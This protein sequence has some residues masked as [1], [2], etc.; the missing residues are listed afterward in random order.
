MIRARNA[1]IAFWFASLI[2]CSQDSTSQ[3]TRIRPDLAKHFEKANVRGSF[4]L[5]EMK[6]DTY[7]LTDTN[8]FTQGFT[9]ASTFKI[10]NSLIG[11]ETGVI[12]DENFVIQWDGV[13][14]QREEWNCDQDLK[15]A[16]KNSTVPY[17]QE[18]ARRV[19][20]ERMKQWLDNAAYGNGDTS[21]G[22]DRFWLRGGLRIS[23]AQQLDFLQRLH[24]EDL[25]FSKRSMAIVKKI[26]ME[27]ENAAY[28]LRSKTGWGEQ[29]GMNIGWYVGYVTT[30]DNVYFFATCLQAR[31]P[32]DNFAAN[33]KRITRRILAELDIL[34][35]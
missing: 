24:R 21:G 32:D 33:R 5:Y 19:G 25:P 14:R 20:A 3:T 22:I 7:I 12:A 18:L 35:E 8:Q 10:C 31:T 13:K 2:L 26:M 29:D 23:P 6:N 28:T 1:C 15:T 4:S 27:E 17:Y 34:P 16:Y 11:V 9:P 30:A